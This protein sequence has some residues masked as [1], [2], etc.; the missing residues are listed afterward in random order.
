MDDLS[1]PTPDVLV[2]RLGDLAQAAL[3]L[4][5]LPPG[6]TTR[7][8]NLSENATFLVEAPDGGRTVLRVHRLGYHSRAAI[9][10]ELDWM[11]ALYRDAGVI[12][13]Q[14]IPGRDG[15][16]IQRMATPD[17]SQPRHMV[18]FHFIEGYEPSEDDDLIEPFERLGAVSARLHQ[19]AM[20]WHRPP[21]FE[22][23]V[24][25]DDSI[26]GPNPLWG[27]WRRA[28]GMDAAAVALL[29]RQAAVIRRRLA[30]FGRA[31]DRYTLIHADI[32][33]ANLLIVDDSTRVIDFD[34][35][36]FGWLLYDVATALSFF[37]HSPKVPDLVDAW[38]RGYRTVRAL[39]ADDEA[40]IPTFIMLR[41]MALLAWSGTHAETELAQ[42]LGPAYTRGSCDLAE[43]YLRR[44]G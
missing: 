23:L 4:W 22:R 40:E 44:F 18:L 20:G 35:S 36:G 41:R 9:Q 3:P 19:H 30:R 26:L 33:L 8:I 16:L 32:R 39:P 2:A 42:S 37:E 21:G 27:D 29:E 10:S 5:D 34:D 24:W 38:L 31:R 13:P 43:D 28:V 12:T 6:C 15:A 14:A 1:P 25:D 7:L 17:L 11:A